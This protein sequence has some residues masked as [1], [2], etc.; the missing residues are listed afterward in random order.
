MQSKHKI[1]SLTS[2]ILTTTT[3]GAV[4]AET[5]NNTIN[6]IPF[7]QQQH[8]V[9]AGQQGGEGGESGEGGF[10]AKTLKTDDVAFGTALEVIHAHY[11]IGQ[12]LYADGDYETA[13]SFFGH[14]ISE[15]LVELQS[16]FE[17]RKIESPE[18]EMYA[19]L[20]IAQK[21]NQLTE[22]KLG[23]QKVLTKIDSAFE[24][25]TVAD[26]EQQITNI[27]AINAELIGR[28]KIEYFIAL[29]T[30]AAENL[31]DS[32]GYFDAASVLFQKNKQAY[33]SLNADKASE[34]ASWF[35]EIKPF[36]DNFH[37]IDDAKNHKKLAGLMA[38]IELG[39]TN[40]N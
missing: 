12:K 19:L 7:Y 9:Y 32:I 28:S 29:D 24:K 26:K 6:I 39:L 1:I 23:I 22:L 37:E 8:N 40:L 17:F 33:Q 15:V 5:I 2:L 11:L 13:E 34:L 38:K 27:A 25:M 18:E 31:Q 36:F 3:I 20:D 21:P 35:T 4:Y 30:D 10:D 16:A 14:P